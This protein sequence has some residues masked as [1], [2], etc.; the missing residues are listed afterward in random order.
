MNQGGSAAIWAHANAASV[1]DCATRSTMPGRLRSSR[2]IS[3]SNTPKPWSSWRE[4]SSTG[5]EMKAAVS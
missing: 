5:L 3:W 1:V 4:R 2:C